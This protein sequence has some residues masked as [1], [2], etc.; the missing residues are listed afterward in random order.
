MIKFT[1][2]QIGEFV[3]KANFNA[4]TILRKDP[5]WP[6]VSIVTPSYNQGQ[7]LERTIL[8]V[9]NQNYPNLEYIIIDG[10]STDGT[11]DVI[12]KYEK[13]IDYWVSEPDGG[14]Y[15][16]MN[17]GWSLARDSSFVLFLGAGDR[18][19][20]LP[21]EIPKLSI[22]DVI[23]GKVDLGEGKFFN[24]RADIRLRLG[25]TLHHQA[26]LINKSLSP[27]PPFNTK[28]KTY[29]DFD[30]NQRLLKQGVKFIHSSNF[31][32]YAMP[33]GV[34]KKLCIN[35]SASIVRKNF[36]VFW[37]MLALVYYLYQGIKFGFDRLSIRR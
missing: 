31:V 24:S 9:L 14:I 3:S 21:L 33:G 4:R 27:E 8:S 25:N 37:A 12:K 36:G 6:K 35:E 5:S 2:A 1:S 17:K 26:L 30:F 22:Y 10:G 16:A 15:D 11:L 32:S 7:F 29:A 18:L 34:S 20:A 28:Y 19:L 13:A 23:F